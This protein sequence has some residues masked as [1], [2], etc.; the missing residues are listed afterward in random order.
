MRCNEVDSH[1]YRFSLS[2][3]SVKA[4]NLWKGLWLAI[5]KEFWNHRNRVIFNNRK[6]EEVEIFAL[7]QMNVWT[8]ARFS[9]FRVKGSLSEWFMNPLQFLKQA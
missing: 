9:G 8:W 5:T 4:N 3:F 6:V 7:A 2:F 1:F